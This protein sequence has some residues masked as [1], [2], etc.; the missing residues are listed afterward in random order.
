MRRLLLVAGML[1]VLLPG[2]ASAVT[3]MVNGNTPS[4]RWQAAVDRSYIPTPDET[5]TLYLAPCPDTY[6]EG[7]ASE[8]VD[9]EPGPAALWLRPDYANV[10]RESLMHGLGH[11]FDALYLRDADRTRFARIWHRPEI[12]WWDELR[13][14]DADLNLMGPDGS[15]GEPSSAGEWFADGY[16]WCALHRV[17]S[18]RR[19]P[20][21]I[22]DVD[23]LGYL[24]STIASDAW[25]DYAATYRRVAATCR[26]IRTAATS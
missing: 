13:A 17:R 4:A 11:R 3:L 8:C 24:A 22:G 5:L 25:A 7:D 16:S 18:L 1:L 6:A 10:M 20:A 23:D 26:L 19:H 15:M 9:G 21:A 14:Y 12:G 2:G